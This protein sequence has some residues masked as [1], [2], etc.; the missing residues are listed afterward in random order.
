MASAPDPAFYWGLVAVLAVGTFF[1]R[2]S[3]L[4]VFTWLES[5]PDWLER[6]LRYVPAAVLAAILVPRVVFADGT[7][8]VGL[9]NEKLLALFPAAIV[10]W[11]TENIL[12]TVTAGMVV[13]W[14][15]TLL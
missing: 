6:A 10:A 15:L 9:G 1:V 2:L 14:V 12:A 5:V 8:L 4:E 3:F 11:Y 7:L 13:L